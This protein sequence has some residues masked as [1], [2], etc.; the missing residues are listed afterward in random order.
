LAGERQ[1]GLLRRTP[2]YALERR[3]GARFTAFA[4]WE[5]PLHYAGPTP[6]QKE[7]LAVREGLAVF[8]V[9]HMARV[10]LVGPDATTL[11]ARLATADVAGAAEGGSLYTLFCNEQG[12]ILEDLILYRLAEQ[13]YLAVLNAANHKRDL[14]WLERHA[15]GLSVKLYDRT[16]ELG[17][18]ALQGPGSP[19][20]LGAMGWPTPPPR[21]AVTE[22]VAGV[23]SLICATGY[24]GERGFELIVKA[25][26][27]EG[28]FLLLVESGATP[29]GLAARDSLR[30]EAGLPLYGNELTVER[31]PVEAG[32]ERFCR[33]GG[34]YIGAEAIE[35][36]R[37]EG[38]AQRLVP[39][40]LED[41]GLVRGGEQVAGG[42]VVTSGAFSPLLRRGVG[43][44][45]LPLARAAEGTP[46]TIR[47]GGRELR[48]RVVRRPAHRT[49]AT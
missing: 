8:D 40:V 31:N 38:V 41:P 11:L 3:L 47:R 28:L 4:G 19:I 24:T 6:V 49:G 39:F 16:D 7:H 17:M 34:G 26:D 12:G 37:S 15:Q 32:L 5:L 14:D 13:R 1:H 44:A 21:T 18:V 33:S 23:W 25:E 27:V 42:G 20:L 36:L 10:E 22:R 45:Y 46:F 2:L 43:L 29:A 30:V 35:R 9:S 48:A